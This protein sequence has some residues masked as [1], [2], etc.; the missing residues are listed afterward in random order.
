IGVGGGAPLARSPFPFFC[1]IAPLASP[2]AF[3]RIFPQFAISDLGLNQVFE[4]GTVI[5]H[6]AIASMVLIVFG[7]IFLCTF[8]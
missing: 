7:L 4:L 2:S 5:S 8:S 3:Q 1:F 6:V